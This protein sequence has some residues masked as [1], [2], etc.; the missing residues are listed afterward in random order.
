MAQCRALYKV[1]LCPGSCAKLHE[2]HIPSTPTA[3]R[4]RSYFPMAKA[5]I[6]AMDAT[7]SYIKNTTGATLS[8]WVTAGASKRGA[9]TWMTGAV[10]DPR[11][12]G[13][14]PIVFD[15]LNFR[16]G[17]QH[18]WRTLGNWTFAF[19]DYRDMNVTLYLNDGSDNLDVLAAQIDPLAY[20]EN[21]TMSKLVVD[22]TGD[23]FFQPQDDDFWWGQLPG[24]NLRM[25]VDNAEHSMAT[26]ALYLITGAEV[27]MKALLDGTPRPSF[28]WDRAPDGSAITVTVTGQQPVA[29]VNRMA[30]TLDGYRR[31]FRLVA[32][33]TPANP[34][35]YIPVPVF[36]SA[37]L[38]PIIWI[39]NTIGP[40]SFNP[41]TN[42]S[43]WVATQDVPA[44]GWRGFLVE[45]YFNST[46]PG[47][48][49]QLT[50]QIAMLPAP[51]TPL[52]PF[53]LCIGVAC[54]GDLV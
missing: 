6:K 38:R 48:M 39:G 52:Y 9:T 21:L 44:V 16:Q 47:L 31:D 22:A 3:L 28:T 11:I 4:A 8:R 46:I 35:K 14:V 30:T 17:V 32:G 50:T 54:V 53:D 1:Y 45:L 12:I 36:G 2:H 27:W 10:G 42:V 7:T 43:V 29:V 26:G 40:E 13:I 34:C 33:D 24:E 25:M 18:M 5:A 49:F 51:G 15:V 23:E 19:T 37:C 20:K 41:S